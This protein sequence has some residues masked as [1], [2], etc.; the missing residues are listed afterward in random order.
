MAKLI[1]QNNCKLDKTIIFVLFDMEEDGLKGSKYFV[2]D[3][4]IPV[5]VIQNGAKVIAVIV[6]DMILEHDS[7]RNSQSLGIIANVL[8]EWSAKVKQ[9]G[10][11]GDFAAVWAR[12]GIDT[13]LYEKL[14]KNWVNKD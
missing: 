8:P 11:R 12:K 4:L 10:Y 6:M 14:E 13:K 2:K 7:T 3:Y 1:A 9:N 5:E